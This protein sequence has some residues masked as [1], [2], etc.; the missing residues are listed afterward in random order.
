MQSVN[1][2]RWSTWSLTSW[3]ISAS[4]RK[5]KFFSRPL[6]RKVAPMSTQQRTY[7]HAQTRWVFS[8]CTTTSIGQI[9]SFT[10]LFIS[11]TRTKSMKTYS[12]NS[13]VSQVSSVNLEWHPLSPNWSRNWWEKALFKRSPPWKIMQRFYRL[14]ITSATLLT[15][16]ACQTFLPSAISSSD[17]LNH[18]LSR[19]Q[20]KNLSKLWHPT[21]FLRMTGTRALSS[22]K[23]SWSAWSLRRKDK[24]KS[25]SR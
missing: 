11:K 12:L 21:C 4:Q 15:W 10:L 2:T 24:S 14:V 3:W 22:N 13:K 8:S 6:S 23:K 7:L 1:L 9:K 17:R 20:R 25:H 18:R 16:V 5:L 19:S